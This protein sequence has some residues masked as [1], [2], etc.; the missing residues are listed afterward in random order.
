MWILF[1]NLFSIKGADGGYRSSTWCNISRQKLVKEKLVGYTYLKAIQ[2]IH[3]TLG[4]SN[5]CHET[6]LTP[7]VM[8]KDLKKTYFR[9][10]MVN[11]IVPF[12]S[13]LSAFECFLFFLV[14]LL[15]TNKIT[16]FIESKLPQPVN[17]LSQSSQILILLVW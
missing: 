6:I 5:K 1:K 12:A 13:L 15:N 8:L 3:D 7:T 17:F 10:E 2:I 4:W 14:T 9:L 11:S 16:K